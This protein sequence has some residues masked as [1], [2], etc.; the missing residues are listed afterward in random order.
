MERKGETEGKEKTLPLHTLN[1]LALYSVYTL[2]HFKG[3]VHANHSG[4]VMDQMLTTE[5]SIICFPPISAL[6]LPPTHTT[7]TPLS[8][9]THTETLTKHC[10]ASLCIKV[11]CIHPTEFN[12]QE[13]IHQRIKRFLI[14]TGSI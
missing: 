7:A 8:L 12:R 9:H 11:T 2:T 14:C 4:T 5:C 6:F 13:A 1:L 3:C 10:S